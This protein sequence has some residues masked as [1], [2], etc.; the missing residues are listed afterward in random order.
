ME[1]KFKDRVVKTPV[2]VTMDAQDQLLLSEGLCRQLE[3]VSNDSAVEIWRGGKGASK[4]NNSC[5]QTLRSSL[6]RGVSN[7]RRT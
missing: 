6:P 4:R 3:I 5:L 2:Y 7:V 1:I